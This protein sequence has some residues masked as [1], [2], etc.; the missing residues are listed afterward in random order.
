MNMNTVS[1]YILKF[2]LSMLLDLSQEQNILFLLDS[3]VSPSWD[4]NPYFQN[5]CKAKGFKM[6]QILVF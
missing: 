3:L 5:T 1:Y 6:I 2:I 4:Q